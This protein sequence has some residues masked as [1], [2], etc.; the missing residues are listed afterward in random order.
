MELEQLSTVAGM[1]QAG[2]GITIV[3]SLTLFHFRQP[4]LLARRIK[5]G[6]LKR[7]VFLVRRADRSLSSAAQGL[8]ALLMKHRPA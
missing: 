5:S 3:P 6:G 8:H 4:G 7:Q 1:V 2:L